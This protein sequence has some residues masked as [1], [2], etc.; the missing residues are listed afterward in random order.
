[1]HNE[2]D[3]TYTTMFIYRRA[4]S[5]KTHIRTNTHARAHINKTIKMETKDYVKKK[6]LKCR[7]TMGWVLS[8]GRKWVFSDGMIYIEPP[9]E[10]P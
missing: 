4:I 10:G 9:Q 2:E 6:T 8:R 1:M 7:V 3:K 5:S